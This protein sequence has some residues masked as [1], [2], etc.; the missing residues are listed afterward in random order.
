[1]AAQK[2]YK[3]IN[4]DLDTHRLR[5]AFGEKGRRKAYAQIQLFLTKNGFDHKQWSGYTSQKPM[6]YGEVY[7][8][9]F[10]MIDQHPWLPAC[11]NQFDATNVTA[12]TDMFEAIQTYGRSRQPDAQHHSTPQI[13]DTGLTL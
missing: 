2:R 8:I 3:A 11:V 13:D 6:S 9:V 10:R 5:E 7:D 1:M 4:F 12:E